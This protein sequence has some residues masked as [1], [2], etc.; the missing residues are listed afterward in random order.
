MIGFMRRICILSAALA[1]CGIAL[2][3]SASGP[4]RTTSL[5]D[6]VGSDDAATSGT[7]A[8]KGIPYA[9]APVGELRWRAP[10]DARPWTTP[11]PAREFGAACAATGHLDGPGRNNRYD[12]TVA[13][14]LGQTVGSEDCLTLNVWRPASAEEG[15]P[16]IVFVHGG[17]NVSGY[18]ADPL[19]DGAALARTAHALVVTVNYRLGIF[20]FFRS[21]YLRSMDAAESS[22]NF[23][24]LD[25]VKALQFVQ[26]NATAFGG[27]PGKVTLMGES[28]GAVNVYALLTSPLMIGAKPALAQRLLAMS[29]GIARAQDLPPGSIPVLLDPDYFDR[30][31]ALLLTQ[32]LVGDGHAADPAAAQAYLAR[33]DAADIARYLR[34]R[35]AD[36]LLSQVRTGLTAA[37]QANSGPIADGLVM[38]K[39]PIGAI[40]AGHYLKV[41]VLAGNTRDEAKLFAGLLAVSPALGGVSGQR[42]G[43]RELFALASRYDPDAPAQIRIDQWIPA[44]YLPVDAPGT[45]FDARIRHLDALWF[46]PLRDSVLDALRSRQDTVWHYRFDWAREPA[47]FDRIYGASHAFDLYFTFGS[48]GPSVLSRLLFSKANAPGRLALSDAM[49]R[50]IGAFARNGDP[51]D[52]VLGTRWPAWPRSLVFDATLDAKRISV[53]P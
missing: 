42:I 44:Q 46:D 29:G 3:S 45:G 32:S 47:P 43:E 40:R 18:T 50:S 41:P 15:L 9:Q 1:W 21:P 5:G 16:V 28:A 51:N 4:V 39:D 14:S 19:Y 13:A 17:S 48:F 52:A 33:H 27:D 31:A 25:I 11:R 2:A 12:D 38:S 6:V 30:Q 53:T 34:G 10:V 37:R 36:A 23:A 35:S 20:G 24:L 8:W 26:H 7:L 22:G 49:M